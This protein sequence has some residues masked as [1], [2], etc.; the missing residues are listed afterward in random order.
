M[1]LKKTQNH[2]IQHTSLYVTDPQTSTSLNCS[3]KSVYTGW[4][5]QKVGN[6]MFKL[7]LK[8]PLK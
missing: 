6:L 5:P 3:Q 4:G 8:M 2:S 7:S 1:G